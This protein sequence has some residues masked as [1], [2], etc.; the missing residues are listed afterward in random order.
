MYVN[1]SLYT[2]PP[3]N[4]STNIS[5]GITTGLNYLIEVKAENDYGESLANVSATILAASVPDQMAPNVLT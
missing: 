5:T 1:S 2:V 4:S 3:A